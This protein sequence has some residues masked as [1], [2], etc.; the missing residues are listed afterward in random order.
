MRISEIARIL[1]VNPKTLRYWEE[2]GLLPPPERDENGYRIY[3]E[4]HIKLC[5]FILKAK[6]VGFT[7]REIKEIIQAKESG[8]V[9][10]CVRE[11]IKKKIE[12]LERRKAILESLLA[13]SPSEGEIC[14]IIESVA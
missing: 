13:G 14:P 4:K 1:G 3:S 5:K 11:K 9:C 6:R 12:E 7:L 2:I 8:N 10:G